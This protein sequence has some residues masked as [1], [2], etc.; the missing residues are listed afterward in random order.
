MLN[1]VNKSV[2][3]YKS[4]NNETEAKSRPSGQMGKDE[5]IPKILIKY[6]V[7]RIYLRKFAR[8]WEQHMAFW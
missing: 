8:D 5:Y 6:L 3:R 1:I 2:F 4:T 7:V